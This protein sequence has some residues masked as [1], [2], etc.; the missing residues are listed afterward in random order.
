[1][2]A[3][4]PDARYD[5]D[6]ASALVRSYYR[7]R[8]RIPQHKLAMWGAGVYGLS[9]QGHQRFGVFPMLTADDLYDDSQFDAGEKVV[10][11]TEPSVVKTP[12]DVKSLLAIR[13]RSHRGTAELSADGH[14][15]IAWMLGS[16][17]L[18]TAAAVVRTIRGPRSAVDALVYLGM[19]LAARWGMRETQIW[20]RD[21]SS[22]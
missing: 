13:R 21:E 20:E 12:A 15:P 22:R 7:A 8:R 19:A 5:S 1:M 18:D 16:S 4:R 3:A 10:V 2:L 9:E 17:G 11:A 14:G 6:G